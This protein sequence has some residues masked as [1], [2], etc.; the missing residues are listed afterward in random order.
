MFGQ[1][2]LTLKTILCECPKFLNVGGAQD[3]DF[4]LNIMKKEYQYLQTKLIV[5]HNYLT[6]DLIKSLK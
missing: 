4:E 2:V 5:I 3:P 1:F 6:F